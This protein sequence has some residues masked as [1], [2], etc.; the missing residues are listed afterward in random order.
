[1]TQPTGILPALDLVIRTDRAVTPEGEGPAAIGIRGGRIAVVTDRDAPLESAS[2]RTL[3]PDEALIPGVVD[4]HVHVNEPGR[5]E[6][7]GFTTATRAAAAGGTTTLIDMPLNSIPSTTTVEALRRKREAAT[8]Q[9]R[10]DVGFWGGAVPENVGQLRPLWDEGVFGF[11]CFMAPS[12]VDEFGHLDAEQLRAHLTEIASF[13]GL[14]IVHAEDSAMLTE[15]EGSS[16]AGF[17]ASRPPAAEVSSIATVIAAA[18]DTGARVHILHLATAQAVP[19]IVAARAEGVRITAESCPHYL[20]FA[21]QEIADGSTQFK[22]CPPIREESEREGLWR[23]LQAGE[24]SY[25]ASDHSPCTADLK[26]LDIGDFG[27]AWG[28]IASV[29]LVLTAVWT[30]AR[31]RGSSLSDVVRWLSETPA[32][33]VGLTHKGRI[34][35]GRDADLVVFAPEESTTIDVAALKHRNPVSPYHGHDLLGAVRATYLR[36]RLLGTD[37]PDGELLRRA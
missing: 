29:Q 12:G 9:C 28:G 37:A 7:E 36:G 34:E 15:A 21:A 17:V 27:L 13:D 30:G 20:S 35:E 11:K 26:R 18:R 25:I 5:T 3:G 31:A 10:M 2:E 32:A 8:T 14:M 33:N 23:A 24:I 22:C 1:M 16:Y 19:E 6:W 4:T